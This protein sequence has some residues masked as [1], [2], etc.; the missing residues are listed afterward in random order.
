MSITGRISTLLKEV[1]ILIPDASTFWR[2]GAFYPASYWDLFI[3]KFL[4]IF[5]PKIPWWQLWRLH[6]IHLPF[7]IVSFM[8]CRVLNYT[9][10][11]SFIGGLFLVN[12]PIN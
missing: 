4:Q 6:P 2:L 1:N 5:D 9:V 8:V 7:I 11:A 10:I 12:A 3:Y